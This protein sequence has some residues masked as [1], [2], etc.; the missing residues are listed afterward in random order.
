MLKHYAT[1]M[2]LPIHYFNSSRHTPYT[3]MSRK[4]YA[5]FKGGSTDELAQK[6]KGDDTTDSGQEDAQEN[7][8]VGA[9]TSLA[10][11][12]DSKNNGSSK[13]F[14]LCK[15]DGETGHKLKEDTLLTG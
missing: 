2:P 14:S 6:L 1:I 9:S 15:L 7:P 3:S 4:A 12:A 8:G 13:G 11:K 5:A 10:E